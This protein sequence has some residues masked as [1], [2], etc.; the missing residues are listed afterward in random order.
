VWC[1]DERRVGGGNKSA[2]VRVDESEVALN[3]E[4]DIVDLEIISG[5]AAAEEPRDRIPE[6]ARRDTVS[7]V[8]GDVYVA[9]NASSVC[10]DVEA[11]P[12]IDGRF[13]EGRSRGKA[14][15]GEFHYFK[16]GKCQD[17]PKKK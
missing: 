14:C 17:S 2:A 6:W 8:V 5:C 4:N 10:S 12:V 9:P 1:P 13:G 15:K 16:G 3:A 7:D 11:V